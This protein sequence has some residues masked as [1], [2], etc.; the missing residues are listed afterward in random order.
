MVIVARMPD[1]ELSSCLQKWSRNSLMISMKQ[2]KASASACSL[3]AS[4][5]SVRKV[6]R[7]GACSSFIPCTYLSPGLSLAKT[8]RVRF[9][10]SLW[11][12]L[13]PSCDVVCAPAIK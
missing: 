1:D 4:S 3:S 2:K 5:G 13:D 9:M 10:H 8:K 6:Q 7:S 11:T 12:A